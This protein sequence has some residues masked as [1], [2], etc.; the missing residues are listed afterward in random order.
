MTKRLVHA[1][2]CLGFGLFPAGC[3]NFESTSNPSATREKLSSNS[4]L[5][6]EQR[7][8]LLATQFESE[9]QKF[10]VE[11]QK[12]EKILHA[13]QLEAEKHKHDAE[14]REKERALLAQH[15]E[16]EKQ[17]NEF[18]RQKQLERNAAVRQREEQE[19]ATEFS[20]DEF[21]TLQETL[22]SAP[23]SL[24]RKIMLGTHPTGKYESTVKPVVAL[25]TDR[26]GISVSV[27]V[28][29]IGGITETQYETTYE[30]TITKKDGASRLR[31]VSDSAF[32]QVS[33]GYLQ[34][35]EYA[36]KQQFPAR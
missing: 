23:Q 19:R 6:M 29:W 20:T 26:K 7:H 25:A 14:T 16:L 5:S 17:K 34:Q 36:L 32:F 18:E 11:K 27:T 28:S 22:T 33:P 30:F 10:E 8:A 15:L 35:T 1:I 12:Q 13:T 24:G 3:G 4:D 2:V 9:K 21:R 31:V